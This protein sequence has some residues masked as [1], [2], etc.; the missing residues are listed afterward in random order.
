MLLYDLSHT[1][2][3]KARTGV[4]RVALELRKA[5]QGLPHPIQDYTHDPYLE[6][7]R[8]LEPWELAA[9]NG[10]AQ[11]AKRRG[12]YW[13]WTA[14]LKGRLRRWTAPSP[15]S[16][17]LPASP[18]G[19]FTPEI[20]TQRTGRHL[21]AL[22]NKLACPKVALFHDA[23]SLQLPEMAPSSAVS[24]FPAYLNELLEF[25][26]VIAV[27]EHSRQALLGYWDWA[28]WKET[29]EVIVS[30]LGVDHL[31]GTAEAST[32]PPTN[33]SSPPLPTVLC[34]GSIEGRKNHLTLLQACEQLWGAGLRFRLRLIGTLQR[35]TGKAAMERIN[36]LQADGHPIQYD[37][38][39]TDQDL[40]QA[41]AES[42]FTVYPSLLEGF[43]LPV[44]E[45]LIHGKPCICS[46][47][48]ATAET[49]SG[50]G[51][52]TVDPRSADS[53]AHGIRDLIQDSARR[54]K[55]TE[56]A[57]GRTPPTWSDSARRLRD[58]MQHLAEVHYN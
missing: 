15:K 28:G 39:V 40:Q 4:Q 35:A 53:L 31:T 12:A 47:I 19:F 43:G 58:W 10:P 48:G 41:Y 16:A 33:A 30:S 24:R 11:S 20:F 2:H 51:C 9:V 45:S 6:R 23:I 52:L 7:W 37:G 8:P 34:V 3:S 14:Q 38:W 32:P 21:P 42:T 5:L 27:S 36:K 57:K 26:G 49:A 22:F 46:K 54:Q 17:E 50:G 55:L 56:E 44:W 13:P 25:D 29:P 1:S 18:T